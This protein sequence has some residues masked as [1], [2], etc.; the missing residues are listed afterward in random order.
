MSNNTTYLLRDDFVADPAHK[1]EPLPNQAVIM[2]YENYLIIHDGKL[3]LSESVLE[4]LRLQAE[5]KRR[6]ETI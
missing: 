4:D 3:R 2:D 1:P 6:H 5:W